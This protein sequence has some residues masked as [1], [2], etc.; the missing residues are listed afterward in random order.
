[1]SD[2][3]SILSAF[4]TGE[5]QFADTLPS[6]EINAM[7]T[8][9]TLSIKAQ[10][11]TYY[12]VINTERKPYDDVRVRKAL[13]L[14]IDR[15]FIVNS[16]TK[17]NQ[18]P[19]GAFV[20]QGVPDAVPGSDFRTNGSEYID[21]SASAYASNVA[22]AKALLADAGYPNGV[23][24]PVIDFITNSGTGHSSI[25]E[26][27]QA[28]WRDNLG[29]R[30][31]IGTQEWAVFQQTRSDGGFDVARHGWLG[32]YVDPMTFLDM[33]T[34]SS[35]QNDSRWR[36]AAYDALIR[37]AKTSTD[38]AVRM[39]ALHQA[40]KMLIGDSMAVIPI[41]YYSDLFLTAKSLHDVVYSPL[42]FKYFMW[43][44]LDN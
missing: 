24:F 40:E 36:N 30:M 28:M 23:G 7:K 41:Y 18:I 37:T 35:G 25:A 9:G 8:A 33:W 20:P 32:D 6:D 43:A 11:G 3:N 14:A 4:K 12:Y 38:Q 2:E 1:M 21:T 42:G 22:Q 31:N 44:Y 15:E 29:I 34:T 5:I 27:I 26:A 16:I 17:G 13:S 10:L 39:T 19:A